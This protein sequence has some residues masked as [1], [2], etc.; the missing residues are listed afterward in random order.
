MTNGKAHLHK[1]KKTTKK[2]EK[3]RYAGVRGS[4]WAAALNP[5]K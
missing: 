4:L 2:G 5:K 3:K 1:K